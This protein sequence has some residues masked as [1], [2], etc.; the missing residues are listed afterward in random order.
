LVTVLLLHLRSA[1]DL[2]MESQIPSEARMP[3][4][5]AKVEADGDIHIA[6]QDANATAWELS[7]PRFPLA[8]SGVKFGKQSQTLW[9]ASLRCLYHFVIAVWRAKEAQS[10]A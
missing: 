9:F 8:R 4:V 3:S 10:V 7:A 1:I 6:L 5:D 2:E